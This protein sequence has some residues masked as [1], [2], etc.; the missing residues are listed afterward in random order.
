MLGLNENIKYLNTRAYE[1]ML[2]FIYF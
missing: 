2:T 1:L